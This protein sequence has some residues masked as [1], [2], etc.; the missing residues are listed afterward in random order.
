MS[1]SEAVFSL[2][3][4]HTHKLA[5]VSCSNGE[6]RGKVGI[7]KVEV[8]TRLTTLLEVKGKNV[9][10]TCT[11]CPRAK[12]LSTSVVR[13]SNLMKH[14]STMHACT[15]LVAKNIFVDTVDDD[16]RPG[17]ANV[18]S[19]NKEGHAAMPS[20]QLKL[21]F[22]APASQKLVTQT[23]L[24]AMIGRYVD[25]NMLPLST[26]DSDSFRALIG[27]IPG[28]AGAGPPCRQTFSIYLAAKYAKMNAELKRGEEKN[29]T[30]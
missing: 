29:L 12:C 11:L 8:Q 22:S 6:S 18:S 14:L 30:Q 20:K 7:F 9:H 3:T 27:K 5:Q 23:E 16:S 10:V 13:N 19:T 24:N 4:N 17:V 2:H 21:D 28:R 15:K 25:E 26:A 1:Q